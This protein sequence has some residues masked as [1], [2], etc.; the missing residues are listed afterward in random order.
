MSEPVKAR[1]ALGLRTVLSLIAL[2]LAVVAGVV[3]LAV[4]PASGD[5]RAPYVVSAI[6]CLAVAVIA[7]ID[8]VVL[9][10]RRRQRRER[11]E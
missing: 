4:A 9:A 6:V 7:A 3:L 5:R 1:S 8:L 10:R 2:P 11:G